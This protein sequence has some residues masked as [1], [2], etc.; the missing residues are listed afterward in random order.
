MA[1]TRSHKIK[2][3]VLAVLLAAAGVRETEWA[4]RTFALDGYWEEEVRHREMAVWDIEGDLAALETALQAADQPA[5]RARLEREIRAALSE[6][7]ELRR[8]LE[9]ARSRL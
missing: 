5:E 7:Q 4:K 1:L 6:A 8:A 3:A 2:L 9:T